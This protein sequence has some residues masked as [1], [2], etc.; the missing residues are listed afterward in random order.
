MPRATR[1]A[2]GTSIVADPSTDRELVAGDPA[3][4]AEHHAAAAAAA[5]SGQWA[6]VVSEVNAVVRADPNAVQDDSL[7][8]LLRNAAL[9]PK[10]R[11]SALALAVTMGSRGGGLLY[12]VA[13]SPWSR[14]YPWS[15]GRAASLLASDPMRHQVAPEVDVALSLR[16]LQPL[17]TC[18]SPTLYP[19]ARDVG[20]DKALA[21]LVPLAGNRKLAC[22]H[23]DSALDDTIGTIKARLS[24]AAKKP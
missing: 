3:A 19:R 23:Q 15:Q 2:G 14:K 8:E 5:R 7:L 18:E 20:D 17:R 10:S 13:Y 1:G 12:N 21:V 6:T 24:A 22:L 16:E 4:A 11:E 9:N